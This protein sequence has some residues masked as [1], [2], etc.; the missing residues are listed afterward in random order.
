MDRRTVLTAIAALCA[1]ASGRVVA[2]NAFPNRPVRIIVPWPPGG[3]ADLTA[4]ML[5]QGLSQRLSQAVVV[6][7][8]PGAAGRIGTEEVARAAPDG[9][10]LLLAGPSTNSIPA[11][12][13]IQ[14]SFHPVDGF[15][16]VGMISRVPLVV[17]VNAQQGVSSLS[18]LIEQA[19][20]NP[21]KL[22]YGS[23]GN[24]SGTHLATAAL[25]TAAGV[26]MVHV[27]YRGQAPALTDLLG[28]RIELLMDQLAAKPH[29]EA[30]RLK[31]LA[32]T[33]EKR[34]FI[35]PDVP[36]A[37]EAGIA[38]YSVYSWQSLLAPRGTP[39][40]V[41]QVL[42]RAVNDVIAGPAAAQYFQANGMEAAAGSV[43]RL[44][45]F[46][47]ADA[48]RWMEVVRLNAIKVD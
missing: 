14:L 46:M 39:A 33:G 21:R 47:R 12:L 40:D 37:A 10:T 32:T 4:R 48:A 2:Q 43:E 30:G 31:A 9:H 22:S 6:E 13:G 16:P 26:Q 41:Q 36:T 17:V 15:E 45:D 18:A 19:R 27:P 25:L 3:A 42:N 35:L 44:R 29:I 23:S 5:A 11:A 24:G 28:G 7:N 20:A 1:G 34:W 8:K 38:G